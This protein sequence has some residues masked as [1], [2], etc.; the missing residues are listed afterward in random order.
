[1]KVRYWLPK[2][3]GPTLLSILVR[4]FGVTRTPDDRPDVV[5]RLF[6][7][8][9]DGRRRRVLA[10]LGDRSAPVPVDRLAALV[11]AEEGGRSVDAV[12]ETGPADV[13]GEKRRRVRLTLVHSTLPALEDVGLV[14]RSGTGVAVVSGVLEIPTFD[15][16]L[17]TPEPVLRAFANVRRRRALS[18]LTTRDSPVDPRTLAAEIADSDAD[19]DA[20]LTTLVHVHLPCLA[21]TGLIEYD[22]GRVAAREVPIDPEPLAADLRLAV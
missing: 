10:I 21:D 16:L 4:E 5:D 2:R 1:M 13:V 17:S 9:A 14:V 22:R 19:T 11:A 15:R 8:L 12:G 20:V 3:L 18:V 6:A 7:T